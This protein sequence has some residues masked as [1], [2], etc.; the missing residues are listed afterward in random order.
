MPIYAYRCEECNHELEALQ[1]MSDDPLVKCPQCQKP[2]LKKL[3][4]AASFRLKGDGWYETDFKSG[5]KKNLAS[6]D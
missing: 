5:S 6:S 1:K 2:A 4:S 3:I